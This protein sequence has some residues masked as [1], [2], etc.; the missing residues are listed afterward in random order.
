[1]LEPMYRRLAQREMLFDR[2][3][4]RRGI[5]VAHAVELEY[6]ETCARAIRRCLFC[7]AAAECA[8]WLDSREE[9]AASFC[10]NLTF[11]RSCARPRL[12]S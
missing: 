6:G 11:F 4:E 10:S 7:R 8:R 2:M 5:D 12:P 1:M 3:I 9:R